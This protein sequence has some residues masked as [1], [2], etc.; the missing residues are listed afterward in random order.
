MQ[1]GLLYYKNGGNWLYFGTGI[2]SND[3]RSWDMPIIMS[4]HNPAI[5]YTGTYRIYKN[6]NAPTGSWASISPDLTKG[7][8]NKFHVISCLAESSIDSSVL[9]AGTSDGRISRSLNGGT[10]WN[11]VYAGLPNRFVTSVKASPNFVN[12]VFVSHSGYRDNEFIPHLHRSL[13]YGDTWVDISGDLPQIAVNDLVILEGYGD[14]VILA[15][16]DGGVY[17][18]DNGGSKWARLGL[19]MPIIPIYDIEYDTYFHKVVAGSY[20]RS[21]I[22]ISIDSLLTLVSIDK[23]SIAKPGQEVFVYP[24]PASSFIHISGLPQNIEQAMIV[25]LQGEI[26]KGIDSRIQHDVITVNVEGLKPGVYT[27]IVESG[28][29]RKSGKFTIVR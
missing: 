18:T 2:S 26:V 20:A 24:N 16:T 12:S 28:S 10:N 21:M 8:N 25:S 17:F 13:D 14:Q 4:S 9:Y 23:P 5:L 19:D 3:R 1:D 11:A 29:G 6:S 15:A 22:S 27:V 7:I